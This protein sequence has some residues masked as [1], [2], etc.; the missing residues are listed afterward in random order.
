MLNFI[1]IGVA[2]DFLQPV[3]H[4]IRNISSTQKPGIAKRCLPDIDKTI[5]TWLHTHRWR[6]R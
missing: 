3:I 5:T 4:F 6:E 2:A 1:N